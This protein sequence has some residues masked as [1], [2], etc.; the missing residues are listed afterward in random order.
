MT[1]RASLWGAA[2]VLLLGLLAPS[3]AGAGPFFGEWGLWY[4]PHRCPRGD[5]SSL[6]YWAYELYRIRACVHP[7]NLDQYP[8]G[9]CPPVYPAFLSNHYRC[10]PVPP[11]PTAPY[12]DPSAFY[13]RPIV[14]QGDQG[15]DRSVVP[16]ASNAPPSGP[17]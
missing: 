9:P 3:P 13:G 2:G 8:P 11:A 15:V 12:A 17:Y 16:G 6:H 7:S 5:Y 14:P 4:H 10:P 1:G